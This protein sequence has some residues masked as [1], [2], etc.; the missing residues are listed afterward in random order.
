MKEIT[1]IDSIWTEKYRPKKVNDMVGKFKD[2]ILKYLDNPE[3]IPHFL[4]FSKSPG[5]GKTTLAKAIINEL[6]CDSLILNSSDDRKIDSVR[7]KV[8]QFAVTQSSTKGLKRCVFLDE[9]DGMGRI[10]QDALRNVMETYS[11]NVFFILTCN[12]LN[13]VIE[14]LKS[15]CVLVTFAYPEKDE[16]YIF[17]EGVCKKENMNYT[18][19]GLRKLV[20]LNY[21]NIRNCVLGLQDLYTDNKDVTE[22]T[23]QP[24]NEVYEEM[25][26]LLKEKKWKQIKEVV[27][28]TEVNARELNTLFWSKALAEEPT[29]NRLIQLCCR[30][31]KDIAWGANE[32]IVFVTSLIEMVK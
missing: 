2:K 17:L 18:E 15:R 3:A 24:V 16:V 25:W 26:K 22:D 28:A 9:F 8:K 19:A 7:D 27:L 5:T 11:S 30:N 4:F 23:V 14:P 32:K 12:N 29:N 21:P 1:P 31:E 10:A 13:K 6:G 20:E